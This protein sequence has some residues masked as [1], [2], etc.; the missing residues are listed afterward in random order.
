MAKMAEVR[1]D[2]SDKERMG[3]EKESKRNII[4]RVGNK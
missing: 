2:D 1:V 4:R 3:G